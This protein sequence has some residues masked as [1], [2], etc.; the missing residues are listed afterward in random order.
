MAGF[1]GLA[2]APVVTNLGPQLQES[3]GFSSQMGV[4]KTG[5]CWRHLLLCAWVHSTGPLCD[6]GVAAL[7]AQGTG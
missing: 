2:E 4:S 7:S 6:I 3:L 5:E 1:G